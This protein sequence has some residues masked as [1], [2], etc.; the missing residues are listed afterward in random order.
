MG[1]DV[2]ATQS[3]SK[4]KA[5]GDVVSV[6]VGRDGVHQ[7][8]AVLFEAFEVRIHVI[9]NR[10]HQSSLLGGLIDDEVGHGPDTFVELFKVHGD[11]Q[12]TERFEHWWWRIHHIPSS[13]L[14]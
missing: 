8:Q 5:G 3:F 4:R 11:S 9:V 7:R 14:F 6:G 13:V 1:H 10:V 2:L 12:A